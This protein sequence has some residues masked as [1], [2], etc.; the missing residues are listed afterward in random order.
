MGLTREIG[1]FAAGLKFSDVPEGAVAVVSTA[2]TDCVGVMLAGLNEPVCRIVRDEIAS[3][4]HAEHV[5]LDIA[6]D[7]PELALF[8]GTAA[9]ALDYDDVALSGHP[10]AVLVAAILAEA[11]TT[12][13]D[14]GAMI[15]AYVAGY[16]TWAELVRRDADQHHRKGWHP[17]AVFGAVAAAAACANLRGLDADTATHAI[18]IAASLAGGVVANFG[19][20]VKP[21]Q[22]GRA[23]QSGL[24]A[25]R[26][27]ESGLTASPEA[28]EHDLGFL[29]AISPRGSVDTAAPAAFK[30]TW[31]IVDTGVNVKLYPICYAA[32]RTLDAVIDLKRA[33]G[34]AA[35]DIEAVTAEVS[36]TQASLLRYQA[37]TTPTEAKFSVQ[38]AVAAGT[39][40]ERCGSAEMTEEF[41]RRSDVQNLFPKVSMIANT[42]RDLDE[43]GLAA[44]D[45][46][47][48]A[49]TD[50]RELVSEPVQRPRGH[51]RRAPEPEALA[52][53]FRDCAAVVLAPEAADRLFERL[54]D[55]RSLASVADLVAAM[56]ASSPD[57]RVGKGA[58]R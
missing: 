42:T 47:R 26:W 36:E 54:Q 57:R 35:A 30:R 46:V 29:K 28:I 13:A 3:I 41:V 51:F 49:L 1:E 8:Y 17:T 21:F 34:F 43:P 31:R 55:L 5:F 20:M 45:R 53:K 11:H 27:A 6:A 2:F 10:S 52:A 12:Q 19:S 23:A 50:G 7:A 38:F 16:E 56:E 4:R 39:I 48:I 22:V 24:Q 58:R 33:H 9:H 14:G 18:G 37:P 40:A 25:A 15:A 44:F 32:H